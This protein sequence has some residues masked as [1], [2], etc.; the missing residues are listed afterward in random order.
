MGSNATA[1]RARTRLTQDL[2]G[3]RERERERERRM[4]LME[5]IIDRSQADGTEGYD[6][7]SIEDSYTDN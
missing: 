7:A 5:E 6:E 4:N 2:K 3:E 1:A